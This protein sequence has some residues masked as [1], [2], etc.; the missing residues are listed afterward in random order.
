MSD[1]LCEFEARD[2]NP[3]LCKHCED[4]F[5]RHVRKA[6]IAEGIVIRDNKGEHDE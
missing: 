5:A 6:A 3:I 2:D 1:E 4:T